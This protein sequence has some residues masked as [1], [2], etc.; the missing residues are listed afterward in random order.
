MLEISFHLLFLA[1]LYQFSQNFTRE[2]ILGRSV[3]GLQMDKFYQI[4]TE[5]WP[6]IDVQN[7]VLLNI[8]ITNGQILIF[9]FLEILQNIWWRDMLHTCSAFINLS[10]DIEKPL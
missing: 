9:F 7:C 3:F 2:L 6:L 5:L 1:F 10:V 8:I 4:I